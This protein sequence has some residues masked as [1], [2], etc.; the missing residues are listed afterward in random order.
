MPWHTVSKNGETQT[1]TTITDLHVM[2]EVL[3]VGRTHHHTG[4]L[5][6]Y[7]HRR[8]TISTRRGLRIWDYKTTLAH[9]IGHVMYGDQGCTGQWSDLQERRADRV[10]ARLLIDQDRL[11]EAVQWNG[12]DLHGIALDLEVT[13]DILDVYLTHN[14]ANFEVYR[15]AS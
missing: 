14:W 13:P 4:P 6:W 8:R 5:G 1:V 9:E 12:N 7:H 11:H 10:A 3:K 15:E 2:C